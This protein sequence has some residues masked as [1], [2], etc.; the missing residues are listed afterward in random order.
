MQASQAKEQ[1]W[2]NTGSEEDRGTVPKGEPVQGR[3]ERA[4]PDPGQ[5]VAAAEPVVPAVGAEA[6]VGKK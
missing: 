6:E 1:G 2:G 5:V 3:G 4:G